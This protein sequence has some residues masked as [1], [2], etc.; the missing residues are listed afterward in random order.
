MSFPVART[1]LIDV[2]VRLSPRTPIWPDA[3]RFEVSQKRIELDGGEVA[4][5]S[6]FSMTPHCGTHIDAPLHFAPAG[7]PID[8]VDLDLLVGPCRVWEHL[9]DM[10]IG[11]DDLLAMGFVAEKRVLFKTR[12]SASLRRGEFDEG[13]ISFLPDA[14][15]HFICSGVKLL[16]T[17]GFS[18]GPF[19][20]LTNRNHVMFCGAGGIIIEVLDLMDVEAGQYNLIALPIKLEGVEGAP[21]R[22]LLLRPE[23]V[24]KVFGGD[25]NCAALS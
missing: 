4:M 10:H 14:I 3:P 11:K 21:A 16:G 12:N 18:I 25:A 2:T 23:D 24:N 15:E 7:L 9:G 1:R 6:F 5:G 19:G 13:F 20:E 22:V 8:A 17:D